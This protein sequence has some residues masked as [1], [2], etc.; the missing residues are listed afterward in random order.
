MLKPPN[1]DLLAAK[2]KLALDAATEEE[3]PA[4]VRAAN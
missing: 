1:I 3:R 2:L 4:M